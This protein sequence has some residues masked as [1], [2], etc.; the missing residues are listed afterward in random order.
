MWQ[1]VTSTEGLDAPRIKLR[2][3]RGDAYVRL[4]EVQQGEPQAG[5]ISHNIVKV[6]GF[7]ALPTG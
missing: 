1:H 4:P 3:E 7:V 6:R 2:Q 5:S